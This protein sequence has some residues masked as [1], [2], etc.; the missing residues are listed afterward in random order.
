MNFL[1]II[2]TS[3]ILTCLA[4]PL[5][6][7]LAHRFNL[8]DDPKKRPHP[9]HIQQRI[10][11]RAGGLAIFLG[12]FISILIFIPIEKHILGVI[13]ALVILLIVG[14]IDDQRPNFSPYIRLS[15]QL[16][17]AAIVVGSGVG[18]SFIT[19]PW[20]GIIRLD[21]INILINFLGT[22]NLVLIADIFALLW[23]VWVMNM[24]NWSKGVDGQM[25][26]ITCVSSL[27]IGLLSLKLFIAGDPQQESI[28]QLSFITTGAAL[29]F[30]IFNW[31]PAKIFPGFSGSTILG[32]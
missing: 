5:T 18:I 24:I 28:A 2:V 8:I 11:P 12:V 27:I 19:N 22:H 20:G 7:K 6:I 29:G 10:V 9:A 16:L 15:A 30:L 14:L 25:P 21:T 26:G 31:Y 3:T 32:F 23:I 13:I 4:I 1:L 17:A